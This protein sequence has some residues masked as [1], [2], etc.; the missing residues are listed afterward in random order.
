MMK[1]SLPTAPNFQ[2]SQMGHCILIWSRLNAVTGIEKDRDTLIKQSIIL[3]KQ[4]VESGYATV[5]C[6]TSDN[7]SVLVHSFCI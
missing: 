4:S 1:M 6:Y 7:V 3:I 2:N 5:K